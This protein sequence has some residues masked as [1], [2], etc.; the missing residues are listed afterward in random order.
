MVTFM[1]QTKMH[2]HP[3]ESVVEQEIIALLQVSHFVTLFGIQFVLGKWWLS[4]GMFLAFSAYTTW[5]LHAL[6]AGILGAVIGYFLSKDKWL[7][8]KRAKQEYVVH[9]II[10][11]FILIYFVHRT[12]PISNVAVG[13]VLAALLW[14]LVW[15]ISWTI[16]DNR[17]DNYYMLQGAIVLAAFALTALT[18]MI[19]WFAVAT[20]SIVALVSYI[21]HHA[22]VSRAVTY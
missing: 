13:V 12:V 15:I 18:P 21:S 19:P 10:I 2:D 1:Q 4:I 14:A 8:T 3:D 7:H 9:L 6:A 5:N 16:W 22:K 20:V 11:P 17:N